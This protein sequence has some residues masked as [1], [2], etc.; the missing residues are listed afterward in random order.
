MTHSEVGQQF[1]RFNALVV[2]TW[3][4]EDDGTARLV[5]NLQVRAVCEDDRLRTGELGSINEQR[6][7]EALSAAMD[8]AHA[9]GAWTEV[10][11]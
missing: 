2:D 9:T 4:L 7:S 11:Y 6:A 3:I 1:T 8:E 5:S 10:T